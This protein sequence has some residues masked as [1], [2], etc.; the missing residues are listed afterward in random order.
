MNAQLVVLWIDVLTAPFHTILPVYAKIT[1]MIVGLLE[2]TVI[3]VH[4]AVGQIA[5]LL[6]IIVVGRTGVALQAEIQ[7]IT[8]VNAQLAVAASVQRAVHVGRL[9]RMAV[10]IMRL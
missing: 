3:G 5:A 7:D 4:Q 8:M 1:D 6:A 10:Q 2:V 9:I